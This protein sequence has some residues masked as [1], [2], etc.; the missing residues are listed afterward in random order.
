MNNKIKDILV[1]T[2]FRFASIINK[3]ISKNQNIILLYENNVGFEDNIRAV[4]DYMINNEYNNKY[5]IIVSVNKFLPKNKPRN[6]FICNNLLGILIF[7]IA[8]HI[9]YCHG[10]IPIY[11]S[12]KQKVIQM[13]HGTP[14]KGNN[15]RQK[16]SKT[17]RPYY[18]NICSSSPYF[19][20]IMIDNFYVTKENVSLCGQPRTDVMYEN[21]NLPEEL[22]GFK[23]II[24]WMPTY[25]M[26]SIQGDIDVNQTS[27]LPVIKYDDFDELE[28]KLNELNICLLIKLHPL[29]D[30]N[31]FS[32]ICFR[33]IIFMSGDEFVNK[34]WNLY[35]IL[36]QMDALITDYS[37][38]FYDF[39]L[40]DRPMGF[41]IDDIEE[42]EK[43]RGFVVDNP[44]YFMAGDKIKSKKDLLNFINKISKGIDTYKQQR[45]EVNALT[46]T[47]LDGKNCKRCLEIGDVSL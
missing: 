21:N 25:R 2:I 3:I 45:N 13:W 19:E 39:M 5:K 44:D 31:L 32:H 15:I 28:N 27:I 4:Y 26:S 14:F 17:K 35:R 11:P 41:A 40:L 47:Y 34:G 23:K 29:Q 46:H 20:K 24:M 36:S 22:K 30:L 42:Y 7:F 18:T 6:V 8:G 16:K 1:V 33:H 12:K 10:K 43:S 37:S 38:V 9:F